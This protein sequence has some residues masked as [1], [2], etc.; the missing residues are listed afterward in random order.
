MGVQYDS[1]DPEDYGEEESKFR[2][3]GLKAY[4]CCFSALTCSCCLGGRLC[5]ALCSCERE[6][7]KAWSQE[8]ATGLLKNK[9][10]VFTSLA[11]YRELE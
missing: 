1:L 7:G 9:E 8:F 4:R 2:T 10:Y 11:G 6:Q 5:C 3:A